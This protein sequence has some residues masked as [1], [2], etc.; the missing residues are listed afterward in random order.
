MLSDIDISAEM[1]SAHSSLLFKFTLALV[2]IHSR[3]LIQ[4]KEPTQ[5]IVLLQSMAV[6][7]E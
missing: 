4:C 7:V 3:S 6:Q 1:S 5:L 2:D